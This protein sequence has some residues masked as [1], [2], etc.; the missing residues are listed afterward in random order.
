MIERNDIMAGITSETEPDKALNADSLESDDSTDDPTDDRSW[1]LQRPDVSPATGIAVLV[2][3][4][5]GFIA[6]ATLTIERIELLINPSYRPSCSINPVLSCGSVMVTPQARLFGFPNPLIG[7]AAFSVIIV[8]GVLATGRVS[9][10]RWYW[11]GQTIGLALG[12]VFVNWLAFES[13]YR[14]NALCPYC[15]VVW[16]V[17]PILLILSAGRLLGNSYRARDIRGWLWV[18]L[19]LWYAIVIVAIGIQFW[20]YWSTLI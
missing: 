14:I 9:L 18:L 19:P 12:F 11:L 5:I 6:S 20:D 2:L 4:I 17:T 7:I 16:T 15:M 10:P 1:W 3:G 8:T 13:L